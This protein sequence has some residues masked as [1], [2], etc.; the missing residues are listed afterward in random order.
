[1]DAA[2]EYLEACEYD[3]ADFTLELSWIAE[4]PIE[5]RFALLM[6][7]NFNELGFNSEIQRVPW[8]MFTDLVSSP[9]R[10]RTSRRSSS[11]R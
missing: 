1:M 10:R 5:E 8:A 4:V 9:K 7:S 6:Q 2:R 3:P 11:T